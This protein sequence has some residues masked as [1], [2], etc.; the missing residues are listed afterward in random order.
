MT[1][2]QDRYI[3]N[4]HPRNRF[5]TAT[6]TAA[7]THGTYNNHI[8]VLTVRNR[9]REGGLRARRPYVS[10]V[11]ARRHRVNRVNWARITPTV[12]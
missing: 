8:S 3:R 12:V 6:A 2:G 1:R 11:L 10:C 4:T 7:N 9:L 5:Q